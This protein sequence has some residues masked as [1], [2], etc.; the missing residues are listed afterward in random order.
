MRRMALALGVEEL[1][2][3]GRRITELMDLKVPEGCWASCRC[4]RASSR[5]RSSRRA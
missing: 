2:E 1:D 5:S 4:C 3:H